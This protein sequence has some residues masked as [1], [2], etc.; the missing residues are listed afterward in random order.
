MSSNND[1]EKIYLID[2]KNK[3]SGIITSN[4]EFGS[5]NNFVKIG[6][7]YRHPRYIDNI[8][9][10]FKKFKFDIN[11]SYKLPKGWD[12]KTAQRIVEILNQRL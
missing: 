1:N 6:K 3:S 4:F 9:N 7:Y 8:L 11:S 12:G 2:L 5:S 10:S